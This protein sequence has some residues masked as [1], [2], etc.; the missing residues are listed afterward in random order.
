MNNQRVTKARN[1]FR[2]KFYNNGYNGALHT[3]L[4]FSLLTVFSVVPW[5]FLSEVSTLT[6]F[7]YI[8]LFVFCTLVLYYQHRFPQHIPMKGFRFFFKIHRVH[9]SFFNYENMYVRNANDNL[10]I[11]FPVSFILGYCLILFPVVASPFYYFFGLDIFLL[12][13]S[14]ACFYFFCHETIHYLGHTQSSHFI[15]KNRLISFLREHHRIHHSDRE[16]SVTNFNMILPI[17]DILFETYK[18]EP[19][20]FI[21]EP[22]LREDRK[23]A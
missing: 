20:P 12:A 16:E 8:G 6:F 23:R 14:S 7:T 4:S 13:Y 10:F 1:I 15:Y 9:H 11:L 2:K 22:D 18:T 5:F 3:S 21:S 19:S 17:G